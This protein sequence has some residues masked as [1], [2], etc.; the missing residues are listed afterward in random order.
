MISS[1]KGQQMYSSVTPMYDDSTLMQ[2]IFEAIGSEADTS[3]DLADEIL[4][5]IFP[6][7]AISWGLTIWE[8][9]LNLITNISEG[10]EKRRKRILTKLQTRSIINPEKIGFIV[11][12]FT[13]A[14]V[15][16]V[17]RVADYIF[18][19]TLISDK[20]F[21]VDIDEINSEIK[22]IKPSHLGYSLGLETPDTIK[23]TAT[24]EYALNPLNMCGQFYCGDGVVISSYGRTYES[25]INNNVDYNKNIKDYKVSGAILSSN[26]VESEDGAAVIGRVYSAYETIKAI[27][28][29]LYD[30]QLSKSTGN[31]IGSVYSSKIEAES[32]YNNN[33]NDYNE[34]GSNL[35]G[36]FMA[37]AID[38]IVSTLGRVYESNENIKSSERTLLDTQLN[39]SSLTDPIVGS[40]NSSTI[41]ANSS[42]EK[43]I[44]DYSL[45]GSILVSENIDAENGDAIIGRIYEANETIKIIQDYLYD[46]QLSKTSGNIIGSVYDS[47]IKA[48]GTYNDSINDYEESGSNIAGEFVAGSNEQITSTLGIV[49]ESNEN[50]ASKEIVQL[51]TQLNKS[52]L[53]DSIVGSLNSSVIKVNSLSEEDINEYQQSGSILVSENPDSESGD[54]VIGKT[55]SC[56]I[57]ENASE[58]NE[59]K[60]YDQAGDIL[61]SEEELL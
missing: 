1:K 51:D 4:R 2:A 15:D 37:G 32:D 3:V 6:Q 28:D 40:L 16:V 9:R 52:S 11:R 46:T 20:S 36:E 22:R 21:N 44:K 41:E 53:T 48:A 18:G 17:D 24:R 13:G 50:I 10:T 61:A 5:E 25:T 33:I 55:Y 59:L 27:K 60:E 7:T 35:A 49:Y 57:Q 43:D 38:E 54:S 47:K 8:Q 39:K 45:S 14:D 31:V 19:V 56:N 30:T 29:Y 12:S 58:S 34:S 42:S 23:I 26:N